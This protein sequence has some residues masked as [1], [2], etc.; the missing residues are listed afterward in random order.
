MGPQCDTCTRRTFCIRLSQIAITTAAVVYGLSSC[1]NKFSENGAGILA[2]GQ[3]LT[4]DLTLPQN[5]VISPSENFRVT[6]LPA[7]RS[8]LFTCED[9]I[10][11]SS[12]A[13]PFC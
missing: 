4:I 11:S 9:Y 5:A 6:G 10:L 8:G 1:T 12:I 13:D 7:C 3:T 2:A